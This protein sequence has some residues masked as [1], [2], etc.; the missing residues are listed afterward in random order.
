[1][2]TVLLLTRI[3]VLDISFYRAYFRALKRLPQALKLRRTE[4]THSRRTDTEISRLLTDF[5]D[6][7]PIEIYYNRQDVIRKHP[8]FKEV[9][10]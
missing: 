5:F 2:L 4:G 7:A 9:E 10:T 1:M 3:L 8:E 6:S